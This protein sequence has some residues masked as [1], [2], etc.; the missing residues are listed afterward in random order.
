MVFSVVTYGCEC[1]S[2]KKAESQRVDAFK[3]CCWKTIL[4]V[5]WTTRR[6]HQ[7]ILKEINHEYSL[8]GLL[9]DVKSWLIGKDPDTGKNWGQEEETT[10]DEI[11][12]WH[13][14]LNGDEFELREIV[15]YREAW[16]A[17][18]HGVTKS[19]HDI[20]TKQQQ[21][22][23]AILF[24]DIIFCGLKFMPPI[25]N[26]SVC[27]TFYQT[28][29]LISLNNYKKKWIWLLRTWFWFPFFSSIW[30]IS[31]SSS[32]FFYDFQFRDEFIMWK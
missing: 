3:L 27:E 30:L 16:Y 12:R 2:I 13:H 31:A 18:V 25:L 10:E 24:F 28:Y 5:P 9:L 1:S 26:K 7:S 17:A 32:L 29:S 21:P 14:Q 4:R 15:K 11:I 8:E 20:V 19:W 22:Q 23:K 6:S